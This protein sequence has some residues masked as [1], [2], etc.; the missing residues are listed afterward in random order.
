MS[1]PRRIDFIIYLDEPQSVKGRLWKKAPSPLLGHAERP[2]SASPPGRRLRYCSRKPRTMCSTKS[3]AAATATGQ[4]TFLRCPRFATVQ[5]LRRSDLSSCISLALCFGLNFGGTSHPRRAPFPL[6][7]GA[8]CEL[9]LALVLVSHPEHCE[10]PKLGIPGMLDGLGRLTL[11][12]PRKIG[13]RSLAMSRAQSGSASDQGGHKL[14][15]VARG[16]NTD[17]AESEEFARL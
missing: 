6:R 2:S 4:D 7:S 5:T 11:L 8:K 13:A 10:S 12:A 15:L 3:L 9:S 1:R 17:S 14:Q 16:K